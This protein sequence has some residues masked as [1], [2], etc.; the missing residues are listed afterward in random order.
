[1]M[2]TD[3][4]INEIDMA[5][6]RCLPNRA[7]A[8][9]K[10]RLSSARE[11]IVR[12]K[13][14]AGTES[15]QYRPDGSASGHRMKHEPGK[16]WHYQLYLTDGYINTSS[17][18]WPPGSDS[19]SIPGWKEPVYIWGFTDLDPSIPGNLMSV[20]KG[21][22]APEC[23][24]V[25]NAK[26]PGPFL[27]CTA[28]DD[29]FITVY[30][31]GLFQKNQD[32]QDDISFHLHGVNTQA[33]YDGFPESAGCYGENLRYFWEEDWYKAHGISSRVKDGWWNSL[34][35]EE[36][37]ALLKENPPLIKSNHLN[38]AGGIYSLRN[39]AQYPEGI[40]DR[41]PY[42]T[43]EDWTR[44]TYY[45]RIT[46]PGTFMYYGHMYFSEHV[47]MGMNGALVVRPA[48]GSRSVYGRN[49]NTDYDQEYTFI[50]S[51]FDPK[52]HKFI[53]GAPDTLQY[54]PPEYRPEIWF[55]NGRTFPQTQLPFSWN[56]VGGCA[57]LDPRYNTHI[58]VGPNQKFLVRYINAS[59]Q[60]QSFHQHGWSMRIVGCD[61]FSWMQQM[62]K[63]ALSI[64]PG[65]T[66]DVITSVGYTYGVNGQAGSPLS[67]AAIAPIGSGTLAWKQIYPLLNQ[68]GSRVTTC[69]IYPG[70]MMTYIEVVGTSSAP[71][72]KINW[73]DP[74][75]DK[76]EP[77]P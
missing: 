4:T 67:S 47:Q 11:S 56:K 36:Q 27:E 50:L 70:G 15:G 2:Q 59:H 13:E 3:K 37:Q 64:A 54:Y 73:F 35:A 44:F 33:Q 30:N 72:S 41:L 34:P 8:Y 76:V 65:E 23:S 74:H 32:L 52:W 69:G 28:G 45:F 29:L 14:T 46:R 71:S 60:N 12:S 18:A 48:D 7:M 53:E 66:Y 62:E 22:A 26:F 31:R 49:T 6:L 16:I 19:T 5:N 55:I 21:A 43:S 9:F 61:G 51:E 63:F 58:M 38:Q 25:G 39:N 1:M 40:G 68:D 42:G 75:A 77:L 20:P 24:P 10:S 57:D 17:G